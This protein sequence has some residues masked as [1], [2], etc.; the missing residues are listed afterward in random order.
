[1]NMYIR[2][3][4]NCVHNRKAEERSVA[5]RS[6]ADVS[7]QRTQEIQKTSQGKSRYEFQVLLDCG[8]IQSM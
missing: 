1:M 8:G 2:K 6:Q 5:E 3:L 7:C 4:S